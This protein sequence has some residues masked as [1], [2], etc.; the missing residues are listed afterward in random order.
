MRDTDRELGRKLRMTFYKS[1][2]GPCVVLFGPLDVE[3]DALRDCFQSLS[4]GGSP[5]QLDETEFIVP[6][7][8]IRV[9]ARG[10]AV[11]S[12]DGGSRRRVALR[13]GDAGPTF[14]WTQSADAWDNAAELV[15]GLIDSP[16][17]GHQYLSEYPADDAIIIVSKGEFHDSVLAED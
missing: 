4:H 1:S 16:I 12:G 14:V 6:F 10:L 2:E 8:G 3:L 15:E 7:G 13:N 17:A 9:L 5:V 11:T